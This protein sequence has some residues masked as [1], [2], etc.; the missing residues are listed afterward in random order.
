MT[1]KVNLDEKLALF[2]EHFAPRTVA[3]LNGHDIMV[4]KARGKLA[5]TTHGDTD[6][7][8]LV[9]RERLVLRM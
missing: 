2:S 8:F 5:L 4:V 3:V 9:L 6:D 1:G 7:L